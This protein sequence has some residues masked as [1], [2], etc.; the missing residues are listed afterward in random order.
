VP[1]HTPASGSLPI[2]NTNGLATNFFRAMELPLVLGRE[3]TEHDNDTAPKVAIVNQAFVRT[4]FD[5]ENPVGK[6]LLIPSDADRVEVIGVSADANTPSCAASRLRRC[7]CLPC[8]RWM[9]T[10]T[11]LFGWQ[12]RTRTPLRSSPLYA[13]RRAR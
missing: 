11:S 12:Q 6:Y 10:P 13:P 2:V 1:G 9:E 5:G 3:F 4:Y 7:T 8:S